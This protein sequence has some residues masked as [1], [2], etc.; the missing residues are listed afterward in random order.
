LLESLLLEESTFLWDCLRW[1]ARPVNLETRGIAWISEAKV[2]GYM[3]LAVDG[4]A[5]VVG[6]LFASRQGPVADVEGALL[7]AAVEGSFALP[8]VAHFLGEFLALSEESTERMLQICTGQVRIRQLLEVA[9]PAFGCAAG[10]PPGEQIEPWRQDYLPEASHLLVKAHAGG[11]LTPADPDFSSFAEAQRV[12]RD[13]TAGSGNLF[14]PKA[15]YVAVDVQTGELTGLVAACRMGSAV[16]HIAHLAVAPG[17]GRRGL[18]TALLCRALDSLVDLGCPVSHLAVR[19]D[20][21]Q[22]LALYRQLGFRETHRFPELRIHR[23]GEK[24]P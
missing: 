16:G 15:S 13:L 19:E 9:W 3:T 11:T 12:L 20:N 14:E 2:L 6:S 17:H 22:A 18:G 24:C 4:D 10:R 23:T 21:A 5:A 7:W 8:G 1:K